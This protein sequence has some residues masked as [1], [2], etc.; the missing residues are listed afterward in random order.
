MTSVST[1]KK[2]ALAGAALM[3]AF[4]GV[5]LWNGRTFFGN[6]GF[7]IWT[8]APASPATSQLLGDPYSF[9]H[10]LHGL[11]FFGALWLLRK[12]IPLSIRFL[13]ATAIEMGWEILENTPFI[14]DRYRA[15]TASLDYYGDSIWNSLGDVGFMMLGFWIAHRFGWKWSL[16]A[17]LAV[18][19]VMLLLMRDNL[20]LNILMLV[21][22]VDAIRAWQ[23]GS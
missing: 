18:E 1:T 19:L 20:T 12:R 2:T 10:L 21:Y 4:V 17:I 14:I 23:L 15:G 9:S 11:L 13:I 6:P 7:G 5:L 3:L 22:P 8:W 16:A